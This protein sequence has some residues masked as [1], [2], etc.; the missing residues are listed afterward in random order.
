[1][2]RPTPAGAICPT[3]VIERAVTADMDDGQPMPPFIDDG[4]VWHVARRA[5][6]RMLWRRIALQPNA[7][8]S[9]AARPARL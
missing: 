8:P 3:L 7:L 9:A 4:V 2:T 1:M 5:N 6:G